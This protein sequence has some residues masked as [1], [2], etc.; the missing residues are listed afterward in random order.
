MKENGELSKYEKKAEGSLLALEF[1]NTLV[2]SPDGKKITRNDKRNFI[3]K[4]QGAIIE[5]YS[6]VFQEEKGKF[7]KLSGEGT[8]KQVEVAMKKGVVDSII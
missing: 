5:T 6:K 8:L 3:R 7:V 4:T 1:I 2:Y